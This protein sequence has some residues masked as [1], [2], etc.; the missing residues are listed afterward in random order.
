MGFI[1]AT[2]LS[3]IL[4]VAFEWR[5]YECELITPCSIVGIV[6]SDRTLLFTIAALFVQNPAACRSGTKLAS[7]D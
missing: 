2:D 7:N 3:L 5:A 1:C 4:V 6:G